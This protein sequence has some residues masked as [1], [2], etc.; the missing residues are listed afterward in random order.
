MRTFAA[1]SPEK[2][3]AL[4]P[5]PVLHRSVRPAEEHSP[6]SHWR[7]SDPPFCSKP[8][9]FVVIERSFVSVIKS[10]CVLKTKPFTHLNTVEKIYDI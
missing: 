8:L 9:V 4:C 1:A 5:Q 2:Q 7:L 6:E 10:N 3:L